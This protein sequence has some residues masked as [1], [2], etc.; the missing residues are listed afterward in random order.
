MRLVPTLTGASD[1]Y[2]RLDFVFIP[3]AMHL[4]AQKHGV[5]NDLSFYPLIS[6]VMEHLGDAVLLL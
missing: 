3:L 6:V 5:T 4:T 1:F 2:E